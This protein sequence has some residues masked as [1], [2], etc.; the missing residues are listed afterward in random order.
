ML[1]TRFELGSLKLKRN[2]QADWDSVKASAQ[3]GRL[4]SIPSDIFVRYYSSLRRIGADYCEPIGVV[5]TVHCY[6]GPS[7]TGKS[8]RAWDEAGDQAY[9]KD[10]RSK[11][12][13]GYRG[14]Q[15]VVLDEFRGGI[16]IAHLLRWFDRY[17]VIVEIKGSS[18]PLTA[19]TFWITSN[20]PP[21]EWYPGLDA[22]TLDALMRR[23]NV[24][25]F[26][27]TPFL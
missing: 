10:P 21:H 8:R 5:R 1:G 22:D 3:R 18:V 24:V 17:P 26:P 19:T 15:H 20:L 6:W 2:S 16:D 27:T 7:R 11:F 9:P 25:H 13:D 23:L 14:Q 4:D 12:W